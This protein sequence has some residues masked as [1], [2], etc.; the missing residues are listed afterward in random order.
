MALGA[1]FCALGALLGAAIGRKGAAL[2][3]SVGL[4]LT[5]F[6]LYSLAPLVDTFNAV[7]PFNPFQWTLGSNPLTTAFTAGSVLKPLAVAVA[8]LA[9]AI[10]V[11]QRRDLRQL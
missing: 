10:A 9:G 5:L 3:I 2:G 7:L 8:A 11:F 4:A 1:L 6:V